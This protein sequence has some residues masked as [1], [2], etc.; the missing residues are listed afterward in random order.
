MLE[1]AFFFDFSINFFNFFLV[2]SLWLILKHSYCI[3]EENNVPILISNWF[4]KLFNKILGM[5]WGDF[6]IFFLITEKFYQVLI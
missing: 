3:F 1:V 6:K 2:V 5:I 4:W